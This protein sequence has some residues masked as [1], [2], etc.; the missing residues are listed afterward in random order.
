M[1]MIEIEAK[2]KE[3][4]KKV[5]GSNGGQVEIVGRWI[6]I[7]FPSKPNRDIID[8]IKQEGGHWNDNRSCWQISN[9]YGT[10]RSRAGSNV[11]RLQYGAYEVQEKV[12]GVV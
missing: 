11:L 10:G 12:A 7:T 6:W 2:A 1:T 9:G 4:A 8:Y 5:N 3:I